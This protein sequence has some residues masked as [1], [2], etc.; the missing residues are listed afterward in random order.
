MAP[1][2]DVADGRI[3]LGHG[4]TMMPPEAFLGML[5]FVRAH[6]DD[7]GW[8]KLALAVGVPVQTFATR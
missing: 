6:L 1:S 2:G 4:K 7:A 3:I 5:A 8:A